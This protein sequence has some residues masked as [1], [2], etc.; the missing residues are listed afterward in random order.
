M[1]HEG[2]SERKKTACVSPDVSRLTDSNLADCSTAENGGVVS[3]GGGGQLSHIET[4]TFSIAQKQKWIFY[5]TRQSQIHTIV[6]VRLSFLPVIAYSVFNKKK[7]S[8]P[9]LSPV[10]NL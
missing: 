2:D 4:V 1:C 8:L 9:V 5:V 7:S 3:M 10:L 6:H